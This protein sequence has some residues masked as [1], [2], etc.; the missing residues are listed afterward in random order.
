M[1]RCQFEVEVVQKLPAGKLAHLK[2]AHRL[3]VVM[4]QIELLRLRTRSTASIEEEV[5]RS[6]LQNMRRELDRPDQFSGRLKELTVWAVRLF[7]CET[8]E[9]LTHRRGRVY[10]QK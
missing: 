8:N 5:W 1:W 7:V 9:T 2:L 3:V 6:K 10:S 4:K